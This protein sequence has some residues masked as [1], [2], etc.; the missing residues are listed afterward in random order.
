MA[1]RTLAAMV[2]TSIVGAE[3]DT[4]PPLLAI[5]VGSDADN[6]GGHSLGYVD[7]VRLEP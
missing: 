4:L 3:S 1:T 7:D 2:V 5:L 6:T